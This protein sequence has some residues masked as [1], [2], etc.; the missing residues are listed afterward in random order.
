MTAAFWVCIYYLF[1]LTTVYKYLSYMYTVCIYMCLFS[2]LDFVHTEFL[3]SYCGGR[4]F[5]LFFCTCNFGVLHSTFLEYTFVELFLYLSI[6]CLLFVNNI[7]FLCAFLCLIWI[8]ILVFFIPT[9]F[10]FY[11]YYTD[12]VLCHSSGCYVCLL[13]PSIPSPTF[14]L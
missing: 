9:C 3:N 12:S 4:H 13:L 5:L 7:I 1:Y 2:G 14:T 10:Y 8:L 11:V 6:Y